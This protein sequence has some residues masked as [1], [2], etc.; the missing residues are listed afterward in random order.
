M[1][2][3]E[4]LDS[5]PPPAVIRLL[6]GNVGLEILMAELEPEVYTTI[7]VDYDETTLRQL[8]KGQSSELL[9]PLVIELLEGSSSE[10]FEFYVIEA[11]IAN[12]SNLCSKD[13]E[14]IVSMTFKNTRVCREVRDTLEHEVLRR[15]ALFSCKFR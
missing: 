3:T 10:E 8:A 11:L 9:A 2:Y 13:I 1:I 6:A 14:H 15:W 12:Q 5:H 4:S 7:K